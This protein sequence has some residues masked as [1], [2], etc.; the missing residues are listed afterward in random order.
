M[1]KQSFLLAIVLLV[2][3]LGI[4]CAKSEETTIEATEG[5]IEATV[6]V[7]EEGVQVETS[8]AATG[9]EAQVDVSAEGTQ[10][11]AEGV[12]VDVDAAGGV[13]VDVPGAADIDV[14]GGEE[15]GQEDQ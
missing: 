2:L 6:E 15:E 5:E 3:I 13:K 11:E 12:S 4:G 9:E 1:R 10:V 7:G 14:G 8:D